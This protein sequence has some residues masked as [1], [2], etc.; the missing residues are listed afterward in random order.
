MYV[1]R[2]NE[3]LS[4]VRP[5][6]PAADVG[7]PMP[8]VAATEGDVLVAYYAGVAL[9]DELHDEHAVV[10]LRFTGSFASMFGPPNEEAI[11]GH[12]L[13]PAGLR[14]FEFVEVDGSPWV[15]RLEEMNRV[16]PYHSREPF[17]ALRHFI[18]PFHDTTFEC[19]A[20]G[21]E[22]VGLSS[23]T[24]ASVIADRLRTEAS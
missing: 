23:G 16:H 14:P 2:G 4:I 7:A 11:E 6:L 3:K 24:T 18:L 10:V 19:L 17:D 22:V 15:A 21:V 8:A 1:A 5:E 13:A 20:R 12:P 9:Q